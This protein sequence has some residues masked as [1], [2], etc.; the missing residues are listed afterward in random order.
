MYVF[1]AGDTSVAFRLGEL[2]LGVESR[3]VDGKR[4]T[5]AR[6]RGEI[7]VRVDGKIVPGYIE[8]WFSWAT[9]HQ[10]DGIVWE[11]FK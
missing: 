9:H 3:A 6:D 10:K 5:V 2:G 1:Q 11:F 4:V 8:M 7:L